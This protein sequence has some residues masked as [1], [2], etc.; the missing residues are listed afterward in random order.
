[1]STQGKG[2]DS[3]NYKPQGTTKEREDDPRRDFCKMRQERYVLNT[4]RR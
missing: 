1:M 4:I 2:T 3:P